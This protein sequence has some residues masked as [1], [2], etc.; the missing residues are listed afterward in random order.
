MGKK[1]EI[2]IS[3]KVLEIVER[4]RQAFPKDDYVL[5]SHSNRASVKAPDSREQVNRKIKQAAE[6]VGIK[7]MV[8]CHS[9][10]KFFA[11]QV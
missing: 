8:G 7:G 6:N 1:K 5:I 11:T 2:I 10:R 4:R 9:F 3:V